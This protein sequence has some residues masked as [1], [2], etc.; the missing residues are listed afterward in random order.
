MKQYISERKQ[1][2]LTW[3][4][5]HKAAWHLQKVSRILIEQKLKL[6]IGKWIW[7]SPSLSLI[8]IPVACSL[9]LPVLIVSLNQAGP[10]SLLCWHWD[11]RAHSVSV[12]NTNPDTLLLAAAQPQRSTTSCS[13]VIKL[14]TVL[15]RGVKLR[16]VSCWN[17]QLDSSSYCSRDVQYG[18][19]TMGQ[20]IH[21]FWLVGRDSVLDL[22][23]N[24][25]TRHLQD[26]LVFG[27][28]YEGSTDPPQNSELGPTE[29]NL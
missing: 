20:V 7:L 18:S 23:E 22:K 26:A 9:L 3:D 14:P 19:V 11:R 13:P 4:Y 16:F 1:S 15:I 25:P 8:R 5:T 29:Q 12:M 2:G 28:K 24:E 17:V 21:Q 27:L 10:P 6:T